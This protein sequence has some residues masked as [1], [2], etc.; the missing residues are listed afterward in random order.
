MNKTFFTR[1]KLKE[2][3]PNMSSDQEDAVIDMYLTASYAIKNKLVAQERE[4]EHLKK[5]LARFEA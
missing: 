2:I 5:R 4:I 3:I 1:N